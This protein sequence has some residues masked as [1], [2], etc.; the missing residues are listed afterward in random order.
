MVLAMELLQTFPI[1]KPSLHRHIRRYVLVAYVEVHAGQGKGF[2]NG[3]HSVL[4]GH[5]V[6]DVQRVDQIFRHILA[7]IHEYSGQLPAINLLR[8][9]GIWQ[10][11]ALPR[12][13]DCR[14]FKPPDQAFPLDLAQRVRFSKSSWV[15]VGHGWFLSVT[16]IT[17]WKRP[18]G[19]AISPAA[20]PPLFSRA[21]SGHAVAT[22]TWGT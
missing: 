14:R 2:E 4:V 1:Q 20:R 11:N 10:C 12:Q 17:N 6:D 8:G 9:G 19:A 21:G 15:Q 18:R 22:C 16:I 13:V 7:G 3:I 5:L